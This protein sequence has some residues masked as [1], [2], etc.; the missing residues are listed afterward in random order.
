MVSNVVLIY[1][2]QGIRTWQYLTFMFK[3]TTLITCLWYR[4]VK[5]LQTL[6]GRSSTYKKL[7]FCIN[8]YS[9]KNIW[10]RKPVKVTPIFCV[11]FLLLYLGYTLVYDWASTYSILPVVVGKVWQKIKYV[12]LNPCGE[13]PRYTPYLIL[14]W[15]TRLCTYVFTST[16]NLRVICAGDGND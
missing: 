11:K 15:L 10:K 16:F 12:K 9:H 6:S 5:Q 4:T 14:F 3:P 2:I 7:H 1:H 8:T 13:H